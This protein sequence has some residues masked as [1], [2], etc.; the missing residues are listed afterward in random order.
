MCL[1]KIQ[2]VWPTSSAEPR[3]GV[4]FPC[5]Y[6]H[7]VSSK[8]GERGKYSDPSLDR[9]GSRDDKASFKPSPNVVMT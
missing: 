1:F 3:G 4:R 7:D 9:T 5:A 8:S 2:P 6:G